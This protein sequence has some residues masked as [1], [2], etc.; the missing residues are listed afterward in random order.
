VST[1]NTGRLQRWWDNLRTGYWFIP[2]LCVTGAV[3][4]AFVLIALDRYLQDRGTVAWTYAGGPANASDTLTTIASSMIT[5]TGVVFSITIVALQLTSSQFS[6]RALRNF[7]R[8]RVAQFAL[9]IFVATFAYAF[10]ALTAVRTASEDDAG[11]VPGLAVT[12]AFL[13]VAASIVAFVQF[14]HHMAQSLRVGHIIHGIATETRTVIDEL[15]PE[16][17]APPAR[18]VPGPA[19][20]SMQD[21][22][23]NDGPMNVVR[24]PSAGAITDLR[25]DALAVCAARHGSVAEVLHPV[26]SFVCHDQPILRVRSLGGPDASED[27]GE[28]DEGEWQH[29]VTIEIERTMRSDAAFG[30]RQ[31]VDIAERAVSPGINDPTTAVE[32][33]DRI[34]DLLR[35]L[36]PRRISPVWTGAVD[37]VVR[38]WAPA[39][40]YEAL[41]HLGLDEIRHWGST[42]VR[43][44]R[45]MRA[46]L[47]DLSTMTDDPDRLAVLQEQRRL[48]DARVGELPTSERA[49]AH[50]EV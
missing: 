6:P 18:A 24:A 15:Y 1:I 48:L 19:V 17:S 38:A 12:G 35:M 40:S 22:P 31:L 46:L 3:A 37:G 8:D 41:V 26:G 20:G 33:L 9:G 27:G 21:G 10:T 7:L 5:F 50:A 23:M 43:V 47:D 32:C 29:F 34:H 13:L 28:F 39:P 16:E 2:L 11:F 42:S 30:L 25:L 44:Q 45:R 4:A 14:I 36:T 49:F